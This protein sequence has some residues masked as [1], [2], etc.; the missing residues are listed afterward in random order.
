MA[1]LL[2]GAAV[3]KAQTIVASV[4]SL[5]NLALSIFLTRRMGVIGVCLGSIITQVTISLPLYSW[6]I[7]DMFKKMAMTTMGNELSPAPASIPG[8]RG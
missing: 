8:S 1:M 3:L 4:A 5:V 7:R 6:I 2:N